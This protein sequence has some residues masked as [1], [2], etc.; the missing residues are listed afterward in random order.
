MTFAKILFFGLACWLYAVPAGANCSPQPILFADGRM[1][2]PIPDWSPTP[3]QPRTQQLAHTRLAEWINRS[4]E[5]A[6]WRELQSVTLIHGLSV[7]QTLI[8]DFSAMLSNRCLPSALTIA[9]RPMEEVNAVVAFS[10]CRRLQQNAAD[11]DRI[12]NEQRLVI[13]K[14]VAAG[15]IQFQ[16]IWRTPAGSSALPPTPPISSAELQTLI[17][18][19]AQSLDWVNNR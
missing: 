5:E 6:D 18:C 17:T 3:R 14:P 19:A 15:L 11:A 4:D 8:D 2:A 1:A 13:I 16:R 7:P 12:A 9:T 10:D